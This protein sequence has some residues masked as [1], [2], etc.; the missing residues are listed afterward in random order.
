MLDSGDPSDAL[1]FLSGLTAE[2]FKFIYL[3]ALSYVKAGNKSLA[4]SEVENCL[5]LEPNNVEAIV[6]KAKLFWSI[7]KIEEGNELFWEAHSID[8]CN[9]EVIEFLSMMKPRAEVYYEKATKAL[10]ENDIASAFLHIKKGLTIFHDM[11][12]LL[13]LRASIYRMQK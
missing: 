10:L 9:F 1:S 6:L 2:E 5:K 4:L 8:P 3:K 12:K 13:L 11:S 7:N